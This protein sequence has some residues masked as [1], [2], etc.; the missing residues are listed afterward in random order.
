MT[1]ITPDNIPK[2]DG[3]SE[4][5][6]RGGSTG[7]PDYN[8]LGGDDLNPPFIPDEDEKNLP[9]GGP[10]P[11]AQDSSD[12]KAQAPQDGPTLVEDQGKTRDA[13]VGTHQVG[14]DRE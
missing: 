12:S 14:G 11:S 2:P 7:H 13:F 5:P 6:L 9:E 4:G 1:Q 8:P 10:I 3:A